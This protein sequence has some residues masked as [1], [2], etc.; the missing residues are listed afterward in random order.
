MSADQPGLLDHLFRRSY[1]KYLAI[2]VKHFGPD[3]LE[4][5]EDALQD[6]FAHATHAWREQLP[7]RPEAWLTTA[8]KRRTI[9]LLRRYSATTARHK[10]A[11][12]DQPL[13]ATVEQLFL[14]SEVADAELRMIFTVCH[15]SL[16]PQDQL[17][18]ALRCVSGFSGSEIASALLLKPDT[19]KKRLT[20]A[21][22]TIRKRNIRF[23]VPTGST[24]AK[25]MP[26]VL[27]VLYLI[28][29]EGF[30]SASR[31]RV[32][33]EEL[34]GEAMRMCQQLLQ[35]TAIQDATGALT[36]LMALMCFHA[37]RLAAKVD[38]DGQLIDLKHQDR[39]K[40]HLPLVFR[41]N[42]LM[43]EA[44]K[45]GSFSVYHYEA[46][47]AAEHLRAESFAA[48]DWT[49]IAGWYERLRT[50]APSPMTDLSLAIVYIQNGNPVKSRQ[51]LEGVELNALASR[52]YLYHGCWAEWHKAFGSSHDARQCLEKSLHAVVNEQERCYIQGKLDA[53]G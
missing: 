9:D 2:L 8:A 47:I 26:R 1:A 14:A 51:L 3:K 19:V 24:L 41:G 42:A 45:R 12:T 15:P 32:V 43:H 46:A 16:K 18:F 40:W 52:Q 5:L 4:L 21:R 20:R 7:E 11:S 25:R 50:I 22:A 37:A 48:T 17:A 23:E 30:H 35:A 49:Q 10:R 27:E 13:S 44:V 34:C 28:F 36:A 38:D 29:N 39:S 33:R 31:E 6:T 53:L